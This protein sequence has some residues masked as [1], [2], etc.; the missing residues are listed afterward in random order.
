LLEILTEPKNAL[1]KQYQHLFDM[2]D[3]ELEIAPDALEIIA[4]QAIARGTGARGL[5]AIMEEILLPVMYEVPSKKEIG[6][7]V[8]TA[9]VIKTKSAPVYVERGPNSVKRSSKRG[10]EKTA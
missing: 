9:E 1:V 3:V 6:K 5:R 7:V 2:D 10:E 8:V 4:D